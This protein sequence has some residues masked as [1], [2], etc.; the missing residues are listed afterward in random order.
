[1]TTNE[2]FYISLFSSLKMPGP[3]SQNGVFYSNDAS[4]LKK[5]WFQISIK[6]IKPFGRMMR[7]CILQLPIPYC[8]SLIMVTITGHI[9]IQIFQTV[10]FSA[11][12]FTSG[13]E[14][15][16]CFLLIP[17]SPN[18]WKNL[19]QS[20][21]APISWNDSGFHHILSPW[22]IPVGYFE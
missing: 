18:V 15:N 16:M 19:T 7:L 8:I 10:Q 20:D 21:R 13:N 6:S 22:C 14:K 11:L 12:K 5:S 4:S 17:K 9:F 2:K 3:I 1:M